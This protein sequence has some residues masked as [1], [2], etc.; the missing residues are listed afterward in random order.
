MTEIETL[1]KE[2]LR[3][4]LDLIKAEFDALEAD[5]AE[6][7]EGNEADAFSDAIW[8]DLIYM[9]A[10]SRLIFATRDYLTMRDDPA[11]FT[12]CLREILASE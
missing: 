3:A 10:D 9:I 12:R 7:V 5:F 8:H 6:N 4:W 11:E 2:A 1:R